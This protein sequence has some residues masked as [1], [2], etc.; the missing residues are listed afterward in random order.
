M[1]KLNH[2]MVIHTFVSGGNNSTSASGSVLS[3]HTGGTSSSA[4]QNLN[5]CPVFTNDCTAACVTLDA[6]GCP[7]CKC[8]DAVGKVLK[9]F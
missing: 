5:N 9:F 8:H 7:I 3:G 2:I 1:G 6:N 4:S